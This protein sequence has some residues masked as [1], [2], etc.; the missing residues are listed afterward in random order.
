MICLDV[1]LENLK[2]IVQLYYLYLEIKKILIKI[3][4]NFHNKLICRV[5]NKYGIEKLK[6]KINIL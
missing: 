1:I 3:V 2:I 6:K 4:N 5:F